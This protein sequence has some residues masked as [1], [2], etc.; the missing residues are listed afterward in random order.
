MDSPS[1]LDLSPNLL[2]EYLRIRSSASEDIQSVIHVFF[3]GS[4]LFVSTLKT[5]KQFWNQRKWSKHY[6]RMLLIFAS[7]RLKY[8]LD[9]LFD[10]L[11]SKRPTLSEYKSVR[12][13]RKLE[14]LSNHW[15]KNDESSSLLSTSP[16]L[17][18]QQRKSARQMMTSLRRMSQEERNL[19][20]K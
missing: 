4:L 9:L 12:S 14:I 7:S 2:Y 8:K 19:A 18:R 3:G 16:N 1:C 13:L 5:K 17:P 6:Y 15:R 11:A 20:G 10:E